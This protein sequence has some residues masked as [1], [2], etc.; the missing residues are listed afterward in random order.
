MMVA[1]GASYLAPNNNFNTEHEY[2]NNNNNNNDDGMGGVEYVGG[3]TEL[4]GESNQN[5][6]SENW[7]GECD[8]DPFIAI[9][10]LI[11]RR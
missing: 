4:G 1:D 5:L 8:E 2:D 7:Q 6:I 3:A 10:Y 9:A 11:A